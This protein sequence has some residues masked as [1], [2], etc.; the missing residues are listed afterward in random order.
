M[1]YNI[2]KDKEKRD[3]YDKYGLKGVK[4]MDQ[5]GHPGGG[6]DIF[7]HF[8]N[9]GGPSQ[10]KGHQKAKPKAMEI[11]VKLEDIYNGKSEKLQ[12]SRK[13][14]CETCDGKGGSNVTTCTACKGRCIVEKVMMLGPGMYQHVQ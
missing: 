9:R 5:G 1:A 13:R 8:F 11:K 4:E 6:M 7:E 14:N 12:I 3:I 10:K 2:L